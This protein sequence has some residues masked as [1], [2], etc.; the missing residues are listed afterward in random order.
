M[1]PPRPHNFH[2]ETCEISKSTHRRPIPDTSH[3][4][5]DNVKPLEIIHSDL[6]GKFSTPSIGGSQYYISFIDQAT[7]YPW[8]KFLKNKSDATQAI[9]DFIAYANTQ[10][11]NGKS[12]VKRFKSDNGGEYVN[13]DLAKYFNALGIV[14]YRTP[15]YHHELNGV[16]ERY[17]RTVIQMARSM[18]SSDEDLKLWAEAVSTAN[19]LMSITPHSADKLRRSPFEILNNRKPNVTNLQPFGIKAYVHVP[20]EARKPGT[21]LFN[22]AEIGIFVSYR[23]NTKTYRVYIPDRNVILESRDVRF[24]PFHKWKLGGPSNQLRIGATQSPTPVKLEPT[25]PPEMSQAQSPRKLESGVPIFSVPP[26]PV[27]Q[28]SPTR[29]LPQPPISAPRRSTRESKPSLKAREA[30]GNFADAADDTAEISVYTVKA[31]IDNEIPRSYNEAIKQPEVWGPPIAKEIENHNSHMTWDIVKLREVPVNT[32]LIGTRWVFN[33]KRNEHGEVMK[34]KARIVAQGF[35]Q[36]PG[37][38]FNN[39]YSP[40]IQYDS[41]RLVIATAV[42]RL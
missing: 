22:R 13:N 35:S 30:A 40:V 24:Q 14:H 4:I 26:S 28:R 36:R 16:A 39:T 6:S 5:N 18:I 3:G 37:I 29:K 27:K 17:N 33:I 2:C 41:L 23:K 10:Y 12:V 32:K 9:M 31:D 15:P 8:V 21:K 25:S 7:R 38:N 34:R 11:G 20:T 19:F 42:Y 1:V